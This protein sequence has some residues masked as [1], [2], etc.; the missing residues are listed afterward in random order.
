MTSTAAPIG[1]D[2]TSSATSANANANAVKIMSRCD[3]GRP[4]TGGVPLFE[5]ALVSRRDSASGVAELLSECPQQGRGPSKP[6]ELLDPSSIFGAKQE[7]S[8]TEMIL[9]NEHL[10]P[11]YAWADGD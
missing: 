5:G 1:S 6:A 4:S 3:D 7:D 11:D 10:G 9:R 2:T 8:I